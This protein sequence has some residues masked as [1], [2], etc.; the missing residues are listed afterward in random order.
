MKAVA[1]VGLVLVAALLGCRGNPHT[2][3][4]PAPVPVGATREVVRTEDG[5]DLDARL[6]A[7]GPGRIGIL[8]HMD[9]A[10]QESWLA[11]AAHLQQRGTSALTVDFRGYG[12][13]EGDVE[14]TDI[15]RDVRAAVAFA[16]GRGYERIVL[17]GASMGGTAAIEAASRADVDGV[18][19]LSAPMEFQGLEA[20]AGARAMERSGIPLATM[21]AEGDTSA[22]HTVE[23]LHEAG[24]VDDEWSTLMPGRAHGTALLEGEW[25]DR[26]YAMLYA[27]LGRVW[28]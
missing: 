23:A 16:R 2:N 1:A 17:T 28:N 21:A 4:G 10:D 7:A 6:F 19:A 15:E 25:D 8:L 9:H 11:T 20:D 18:L 22:R 27:F 26:A 13:S 14:P 5:L 24:L 12:A 3:D